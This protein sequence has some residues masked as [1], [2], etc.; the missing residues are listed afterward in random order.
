MSV[1]FRAT[2]LSARPWMIE[3]RPAVARSPNNRIRDVRHPVV[4]FL[5]FAQWTVSVSGR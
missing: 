4:S 3:K 5:Q 1:T 2:D